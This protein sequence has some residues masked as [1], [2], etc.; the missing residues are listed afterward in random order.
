[1]RGRGPELRARREAL[2]RS[3][4]QVSAQTRIPVEYIAA[5][6]EGRL[7]DLPQGPYAQAWT[8]TL[9][10]HLGLPNSS[11]ARSGAHQQPSQEPL[12]M[13]R[14]AG[15]LAVLALLVA[16]GWRAWDLG[17]EVLPLANAPVTDAPLL[18]IEA[19]QNV[20]I[21]AFADGQLAVERALPG[22]EVV[23]VEAEREVV[24]ELDSVEAVRLEFRGERILPQGRQRGERTL[25]F[26][27][28]LAGGA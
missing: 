7:S 2:G 10:T 11:P 21:R 18:R 3:L 1:M 6:E 8:H 13:A 23:E 20:Q 27:D 24:L 22:G 19:R 17:P 16:V 12:R 9:E 28:D 25:V 14:M 4:E 5:L 26:V 15:G